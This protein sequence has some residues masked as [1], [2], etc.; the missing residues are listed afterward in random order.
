MGEPR[1]LI[2]GELKSPD[3]SLLGNMHIL[4][5]I[6]TYACNLQQTLCENIQLMRINVTVKQLL[7]QFVQ[8]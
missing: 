3:Q 1:D 8:G 7:L 6:Y 4:N 5:C 2:V